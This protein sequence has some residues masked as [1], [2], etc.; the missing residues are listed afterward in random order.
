MTT[1]PPT[2]PPDPQNPPE[3]PPLDEPGDDRAEPTVAKD[4][5]TG[6]MVYDLTERRF[7]GRK[8]ATKKVA[9]ETV[10]RRKGHKYE[11]REV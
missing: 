4:D 11:T 1:N 7:V 2:N 10:T 5:L 6:Y 3:Q 9:G 8:A